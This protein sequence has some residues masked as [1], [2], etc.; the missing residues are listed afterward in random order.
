VRD[1]KKR[2]EMAKTYEQLG[3]AEKAFYH[4]REAERYQL[5]AEAL[6]AKA[7]RVSQSDQL[8]AHLLTHDPELA[9][10]Y[11]QATGNRNGHQQR[12]MMYGIMALLERV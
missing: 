4:L 3:L 12:A 7:D 2:G 11:R 1:D 10:P 9:F 6:E 8:A 5:R